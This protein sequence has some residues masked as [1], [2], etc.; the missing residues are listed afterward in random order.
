M[1]IKP[2]NFKLSDSDKIEFYKGINKIINDG[3]FILGNFTKKF[4]IEFAKKH[5]SK[6]A[7]ALNTGTTALE[8][9]INYFTKNQPTYIAV[10]TNT[11]FATVASIIRSNGYPVYLDMDSK[12]LCPSITE[13]KKKYKNVKFNGLVWVH[14]GGI[15]SP[16]FN[17]VSKFCKEKNIFLIE[18]CAH[19]HGS[20]FNNRYAGTFG[21]GGAFSFYPTKVMT[22]MEGGMIITN[23]KKIK[24]YAISMRNQGK[25][26][27][28]FGCYHVDFGNSWRMLE[29]SALLGIIQLKQLDK[30]IKNRNRVVSIYIKKLSNTKIKYSQ[31]DHMNISSQYKFIIFA[32]SKSHG[33]SIKAKLKDHGII[34][35]GGVYEL[36]CHKQPVFQKYN[37]YS[38]NLK[39]AEKYCSRQICLPL[40]SDISDRKALYCINKLIDVYQ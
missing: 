5:K 38:K 6:Y 28:N 22:T 16:D 3:S 4:E 11:N 21:D 27:E 13:L 25:G 24:N 36:P 9:L 18:D 17:E 26:K 20:K 1:L 8:I 37:L 23:N 2:F 15:I 10:P 39:I 34:C 33:E 31:T 30:I 14:I 32:K 29:V 19:A 7:I 12:Y 35:G 40:H